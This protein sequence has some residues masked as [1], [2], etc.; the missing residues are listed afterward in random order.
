MVRRARALTVALA[1]VGVVSAILYSGVSQAP[2]AAAT[3]NTSK[4]RIGRSASPPRRPAE[5]P[6]FVALPAIE[7]ASVNSRRA[8]KLRLYDAWGQIDEGAARK[9][10]SL[11]ADTHDPE[12]IETTRIDRRTIQLM[13]RA[14]YHFASAK[15]EIVSGYRKPG[16]RSQGYHGKGQAIDF[17]LD[18]VSAAALASY[19]RTLPRV[20]V[21]IYTHPKTQFVHLDS[22]VRSF[23]WIDASPPGRSWRER[24]LGGR[25]LGTRDAVYTRALDWP[26]GVTPQ[27]PFD[28]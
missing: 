8:E 18:G 26:E 5:N 16:R 3:R 27:V 24:S 25:S 7:V 6:A 21:G 13:F 4:P 14:A 2:A 9:L 15:I 19:L 10:D 11:L 1:G 12:Q 22:R 20:G 28:P 17:R 23:H